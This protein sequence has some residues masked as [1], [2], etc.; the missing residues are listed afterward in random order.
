MI[1]M[2]MAAGHDRGS[3]SAP[4]YAGSVD[5][6]ALPWRILLRAHF[7]RAFFI[8]DFLHSFFE[9]AISH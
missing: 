7:G 2:S 4:E 8:A 5:P 1:G 9:N 3:D 6:A